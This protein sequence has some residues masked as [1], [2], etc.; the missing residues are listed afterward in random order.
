[1][2]KHPPKTTEKEKILLKIRQAS[3]FPAMSGTIALV[4]RFTASEDATI[5]ELAN[6]I[7]KDFALTT[8]V[9]KVVNSVHYFQSGEV[10][11]ISR[12]ILLMGFEAVKNIALTL[13]LFDR[14][15]KNTANTELLDALIQSFFGGII[16][17]RLA[18]DIS[19]ID[20]EE[21]FLCALLQPLGK[22]M[23]AFSMREA[24]AEIRETAQDMK[25]TEDAA[26]R[27]ILGISYEEI[28]TTIAREWNFP[29]KMIDGM[30][31]VASSALSPEP[32]EGEKLGA[33]V[34]L[35]TGISDIMASAADRETKDS[36]LR[37]MTKSYGIHAGPAA[38]KMDL[39]IGS[40]L[41]DLKD[42]AEVM[43]INLSRSR[44]SRQGALWMEEPATEKQETDVLAFRTDSLKTIDAVLDMEE[45][46][47]NIFLK[48]IQE[49]NSTMLGSNSLNDV[50]R[51]VM[52]TMY[53]GLKTSLLAKSLFFVKN[54][55]EPSME[56][57][58]GF[59]ADVDALK[60]RFVI[61]V[62]G[63]KDIFN[64]AIT[65][66]SDLIIKDVDAPDIG[67]FIPPWFRRVVTDPSYVI[68]L[69]L[70]VGEKIIG[71]YYLEG[72][73]SG[74]Q[75]I[76]KGQLN[77]LRILRDQTVMAIRQQRG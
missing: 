2:E 61:P 26:S 62:G 16:A 20:E 15:Q 23:V 36:R 8:K 27:L 39:L 12:A 53:R 43:N 7:L 69:P 6:I 18:H 41:K 33:V 11:T 37:V 47:E 32:E 56:I 4:S 66:H 38:G 28:G 21:A 9:L 49:I 48:G 10:T 51:I 31:H 75:D 1:M 14:L 64:I 55:K 63:E 57:R 44:I 68:L 74:F 58:L 3:E 24:L 50:I 45:S 71:L 40:S 19:D 25:I 35:A 70:T 17:Q 77:Y 54:T 59:G 34:S 67:S 52:E 46:A 29:Q 72:A 5:S 73:R 42:F 76:S 13:M 22:I 60:K 65:K 30:K